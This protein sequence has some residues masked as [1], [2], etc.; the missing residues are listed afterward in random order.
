M[1]AQRTCA[2]KKPTVEPAQSGDACK[3]TLIVSALLSQC[4]LNVALL[5][6]QH[7]RDG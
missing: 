4:I 3:H 2:S 7:M 6:W 5:A 1:A